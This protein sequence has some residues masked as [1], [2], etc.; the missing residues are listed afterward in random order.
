[1]VVLVRHPKKERESVATYREMVLLCEHD[2]ARRGV[3]CTIR[4]I[5]DKLLLLLFAKHDPC[6]GQGKAPKNNELC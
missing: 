5:N 4:L 3:V 6:M 2:L 1:M